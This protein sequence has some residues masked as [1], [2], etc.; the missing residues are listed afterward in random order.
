MNTGKIRKQTNFIDNRKKVLLV[1]ILDQI[2]HI[3]LK[4]SLIQSNVLTLFS[5]M[6]AERDV[7]DTEEK[8]EASRG[9]SHLHNI[10]VL[11]KAAGADADQMPAAASYPEDLTKIIHEGEDTDKT[12]SY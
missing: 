5:S 1:Q 6:K 8:F 7:E 4:Q 12:T 11:G 2:T 9:W 10:N 3:S